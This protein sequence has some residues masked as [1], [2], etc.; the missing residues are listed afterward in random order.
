M[1]EKKCIQ[2]HAKLETFYTEIASWIVML[3]IFSNE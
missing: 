3:F 1:N 2:R